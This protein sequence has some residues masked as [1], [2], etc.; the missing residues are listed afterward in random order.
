MRSPAFASMGSIGAGGHR[1]YQQSI[2]F[3]SLSR[4]SVAGAAHAK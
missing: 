1:F 3:F 4:P 2:P